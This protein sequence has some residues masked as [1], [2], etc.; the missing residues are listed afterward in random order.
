[1]PLRINLSK[2]QQILLFIFM[3]IP[4]C[5]IMVYSIKLRLSLVI[6]AITLMLCILLCPNQFFLIIKRFFSNKI[7]KILIFWFIWCLISGLY[8][9][10]FG[11]YKI[12]NLFFKIIFQMTAFIFIPYF[13]AYN[14]AQNLNFDI[15]KFYYKF[16]IIVLFLGII[17]SISINFDITIIQNLFDNFLTNTRNFDTNVSEFAS[18]SIY[19]IGKRVKSIFVEPSYFAN[20]I[21]FNIPLLIGLHKNNKVLYKN[22]IIN[23]ILKKSSIFIALYLLV[24]TKSPIFTMIAITELIIYYI[25]FTKYS[26]QKLFILFSFPFI[27]FLTLYIISNI[28]ISETYIERIYKTISSFGN[29]NELV[30]LESSL[31]TRI[32]NIVN[33][34][35]LGVNNPFF[36]VGY[37][38]YIEPLGKQLLASPLPLTEENIRNIGIGGNYFFLWTN[39]CEIGF[40]GIIIIYSFFIVIIKKCQILEKGA[41]LQNKFFWRNCRFA[42]IYQLIVYA[43]DG[44]L[45]GYILCILGFITSRYS[46]YLSILKRSNKNHGN[47]MDK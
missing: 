18:S 38:N 29:F 15:I 47:I 46:K 24:M 23:H 26:K 22:R 37:G 20:F 44:G 4:G 17:N 36:G 10:L 35:I 27:I 8:N 41:S 16:V 19:T 21:C 33:Q 14:V 40:L 31:A 28:N 1:M 3:I 7:N 25:F 43:Y 5:C 9:Y 2:I 42:I 13:F 30:S 11:D 6:I 34:I 32:V 12:N 39:F 45:S